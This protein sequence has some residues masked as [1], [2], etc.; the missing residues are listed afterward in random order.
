MASI[1]CAHC[2][3]NHTSVPDVFSCY[4][5]QQQEIAWGTEEHRMETRVERYYEDRGFDAA[6]EQEHR[7]WQRGVVGFQEAWAEWN[8]ANGINDGVHGDYD[9]GLGDVSAAERINDNAMMYGSGYA[10]MSSH[11][12]YLE[13]EREAYFGA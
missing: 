11:E 7:E 1:R 8:R 4:L 13:R 5:E 2:K 12:D 3:G 6:R 10:Q 9:D